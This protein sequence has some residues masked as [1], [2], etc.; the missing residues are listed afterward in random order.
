MTVTHEVRIYNAAGTLQYILTDYLALEYINEVNNTG[1]CSLV[2][3]ERSQAFNQLA[4]DWQIEVY[5]TRIDDGVVTIAPYVDFGGLMRGQ[6]LQTDENGLTIQ[7]YVFLGWNDLL[8]R[9]IVAYYDNVTDRSS[10]TSKKASEIAE[11]IVTYNCTSAGT[12]GDGRYRNVPTW[13]SYLTVGSLLPTF[14]NTIDFDCARENVLDALRRVAELGGIDF[15]VQHTAAGGRSWTF[16]ALTLL[17]TDRSTGSARVLFALEYGNM[18]MPT[19]IYDRV[20]AKTVA[21]VSGQWTS[22]QRVTVTRTGSQYD[23]SVNSYE[24]ADDAG[25]INRV[26]ALEKFGDARLREMRAKREF[27]FNV[28]QT[29]GLLYGRDYFLGDKVA[30]RYYGTDYV[31][32]VTQIR[33]SVVAGDE[34]QVDVTLEEV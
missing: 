8:R 23:A 29:P 28:A 1:I 2:I 10:Y 34:E 26:A 6:S 16:S 27:Q 11:S 24:F 18:R 25:Q 30:A 15:A 32:K 3:S 5:R 31:R 4:L 9:S 22:N 21:I 17:G 20:E 13:G 33:I 19:M 7:T 12:T 14:G